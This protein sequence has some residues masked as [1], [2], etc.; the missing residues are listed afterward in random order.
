M[1]YSSSSSKYFY[2]GTDILLN[3]LDIL[4]KQLLNEADYLYT[5]QRLL[6]L[7]VEPLPGNLKG[8]DI[9]WPN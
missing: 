1:K 6:E 9:T 8:L 3:K 4:D 7:D 5:S 2:P